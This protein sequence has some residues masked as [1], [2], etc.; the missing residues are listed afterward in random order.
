MKNFFSILVMITL[1]SGTGYG[2]F[3]SIQRADRICS[4]YASNSDQYHDCLG[5]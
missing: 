2:L 1:F 3:K 4:S 5:I